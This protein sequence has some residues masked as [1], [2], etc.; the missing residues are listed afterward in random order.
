MQTSELGED[1]RRQPDRRD[2][3][4]QQPFDLG[5]A[6]ADGEIE[7]VFQP[8][9]AAADRRLIG[10]EALVRWRPRRGPIGAGALF[11]L[12][13]RRGERLTLSR[14]IARTALAQAA[15]WPGSLH[16]SLNVAAADLAADGFAGMIAAALAEAGYAPGRLT[17]EITEEA[18]VADLDRSAETLRNLAAMGI[19]IALDD[20]GAG[21]CNFRYLKILPLD[22]LKLDRSMIEG[23][24][25]DPRDL[26]V[27]RGILAMAGA[28]GLKVVAEGIESE[29][30]CQVIAR[31]G[32]AS[33]QGFLGAGP[34]PAGDFAALA[35]S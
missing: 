19:R 9:F 11:E 20:F 12:V 31:E 7:V 27:L 22:V 4:R 29:C 5:R 25:S 15:G 35:A 10:A 23:V 34:M 30:Q 14:H 6:L 26:A 3:C 32:C 8:Q 13:E 18:L 17:L 1:R 2:I 28:L 33:W 24:E 21:F 16:L